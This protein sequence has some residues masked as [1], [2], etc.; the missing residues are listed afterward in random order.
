MVMGLFTIVCL[1]TDAV[2]NLKMILNII[3]TQKIPDNLHTP[4]TFW[5]RLLNKVGFKWEIFGYFFLVSLVAIVEVVFSLS[6]E[7]MIVG[8]TELE[9]LDVTALTNAILMSFGIPVYNLCVYNLLDL[10]LAVIKKPNGSPRNNNIE[11]RD[12]A[13]SCE[14]SISFFASAPST[15]SVGNWVD[16][17]SERD[18]IDGTPGTVG[19]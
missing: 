3:K 17:V 9:K 8:L 16:S 1:I 15:P 13:K 12:K 10:F 6:E 2:F 7:S 18:D 14:N 4:H 11:H 5:G 19:V